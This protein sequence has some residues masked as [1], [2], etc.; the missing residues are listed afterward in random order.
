MGTLWEPYCLIQPIFQTWGC[1]LRQELRYL[2]WGGMSGQA[3][4]GGELVE[5]SWGLWP[6]LL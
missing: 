5:V 6:A 1:E 4:L 3:G 2:G